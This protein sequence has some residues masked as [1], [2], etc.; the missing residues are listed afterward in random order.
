[1]LLIGKQY[2]SPHCSGKELDSNSPWLYQGICT[3]TLNQRDMKCFRLFASLMGQCLF[4]YT[5]VKWTR[6]KLYLELHRTYILRFKT[7][8]HIWDILFSMFPE[9]FLDHNYNVI[10]LFFPLR[11]MYLCKIKTPKMCATLYSKISTRVFTKEEL[12]KTQLWRKGT[13]KC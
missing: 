12:K 6:A 2:S 3:H 11:R 5:A 8:C 10:W 4:Y 1:V 13:E 7:K 9:V